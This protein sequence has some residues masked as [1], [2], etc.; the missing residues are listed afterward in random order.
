MDRVL[1]AETPPLLLNAGRVEQQWEPIVST[2]YRTFG[3]YSSLQGWVHESTLDLGG[4]TRQDDL[5]VFFRSSFEQVS[6]P[7]IVTWAATEENPLSMFD[8]AIVEQVIVSS[9]PLNDDNI[10]FTLVNSPGFTQYQIT[11]PLRLGAYGNFDR[12]Q[13]IHGHRMDHT[14]NTNF[15]TSALTAEGQGYQL[16]VNEDYYSSLEPTAADQLYVYR[17]FLLPRPSILD[18]TGLTFASIPARRIILDTIVDAE[19]DLSYMMRLKR[20]YELANQ[21]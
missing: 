11:N 2:E 21:V 7:Y 13:I 6:S 20:S 15:G 18:S 3:T 8:S 1:V 16:V 12:T 10:E 14:L 9:V 5:T 19:P 4:Y 17:I